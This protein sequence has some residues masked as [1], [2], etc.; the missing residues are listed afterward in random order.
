MDT[1]RMET[2]RVKQEEEAHKNHSN[3]RVEWNM[4]ER[5]AI[6]LDVLYVVVI[7]FFS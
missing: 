6:L 2:A 1:L 7:L 4:E 5:I 3:N